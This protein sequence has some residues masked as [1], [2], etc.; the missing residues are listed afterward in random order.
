ML[1]DRYA[2]ADDVLAAAGLRWYEVCNWAATDAARCRHNLGYWRD[3]DWWPIGPGAHGHLEGVRWWNVRRPHEHARM[4]GAGELP[5]A[6][7]EVLTARERELERTMLGLRLAEGLQLEAS[8]AGAAQDLAGDGLVDV[9]DGRAV[10]TRRGR[11]LAD[12]V[13]RTLTA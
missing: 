2:I 10:L 8:A 4:V 13:I 5:E 6:G 12:H 3:G 1:A 11:L 9:D 7:R